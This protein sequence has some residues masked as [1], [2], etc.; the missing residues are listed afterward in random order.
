MGS[1]ALLTQE[2]GINM[3]TFRDLSILVRN[4][5]R[6]F[7]DQNHPALTLRL[8]DGSKP[9]HMLTG[10]DL[11]LDNLMC[12]IPEVAMCYHLNGLVQNYELLKTEDVPRAFGFDS[13]VV[14]DLAQ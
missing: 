10:I 11:W 13:D 9:V 7:G 3:W 1:R 12:S 8:Q 5:L 4:R 14:K 2:D 6:I